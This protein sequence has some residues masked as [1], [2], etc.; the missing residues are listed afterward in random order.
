VSDAGHEGKRLVALVNAPLTGDLLDGGERRKAGKEGFGGRGID[1]RARW[2][3]L[4]ESTTFRRETVQR[5]LAISAE[6]L[7]GQRE[8]RIAELDRDARVAPGIERFAARGAMHNIFRLGPPPLHRL[9]AEGEAA[10]EDDSDGDQIGRPAGNAAREMRKR[11]IRR[12][13]RFLRGRVVRGGVISGC[14]NCRYPRD[15]S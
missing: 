8:G 10:D 7:T 6:N 13:F 3:G 2:R 9:P 11:L 15:A 4:N 12:L 1:R 5:S 14:R